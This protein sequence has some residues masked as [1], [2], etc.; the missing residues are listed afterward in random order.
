MA[1]TLAEWIEG[2]RVAWERRDPEAAARL[3]TPDATYRSNIV[4]EAHQ[5]QEGVRAYWQAVTA[6]QSDVRVRMG[7]PFVD[8]YRVAVEFWTD[9]KVDGEAVTLPGCLLLDFT[10]EWLCRRLREYWHF[11]PGE[12]RP[13][14]EWGQ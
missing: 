14:D 10:D 7:R 9:M 2:Y 11:L 3:F 5:G 13:P 8:G 6:S 1:G 4:E 12:H